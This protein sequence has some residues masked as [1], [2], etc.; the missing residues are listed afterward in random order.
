MRSPAHSTAA[1]H[2][3]LKVALQAQQA[4]TWAVARVRDR[5]RRSVNLMKWKCFIPGKAGTDWDG[6]YAQQQQGPT[7][8]RTVRTAAAEPRAKVDRTR[9]TALLCVHQGSLCL[10]V[11]ASRVSPLCTPQAASSR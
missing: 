1:L 7:P 2:K 6:E 5:G 11:C 9:S 10:A 4:A 8:E 3:D